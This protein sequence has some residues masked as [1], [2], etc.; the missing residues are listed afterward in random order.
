MRSPYPIPR[1]L[2]A[3]AEYF[4]AFRYF[5]HREWPRPQIPRPL[6]L[7]E[8]RPAATRPVG[9]G[10]ASRA[11]AEFFDPIRSL[12]HPERS[13]G[14]PD[15]SPRAIQP[16]SSRLD[17]AVAEDYPI[18]LH[19]NISSSSADSAA[20]DASLLC[21]LTKR[22]TRA[23]GRISDSF[24]PAKPVPVSKSRSSPFADVVM[25]PFR[26]SSDGSNSKPE[27]AEARE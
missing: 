21:I 18:W 16:N 24:A 11:A 13:R 22:A 10:A 5:C 15:L 17:S 27:P 7:R 6:F 14:T 1:P 4:A 19:I 26:F 25:Q 20:S 2:S 12:C 23:D 8:R 9:E 3:A